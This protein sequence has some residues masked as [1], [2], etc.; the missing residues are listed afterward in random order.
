ML[1]CFEFKSA[2]NRLEHDIALEFYL[3]CMKNSIRYD[4][5]SG[6]FGSTVYIIA[7][8]ALK[9]FIENGGKIRILCSPFISED[10]ADAISKGIASRTNKILKDSLISEL[11][12]MLKQD[13]LSTPS[14]LLA[15]LISA[16]IIELKLV[17]VKSDTNP[18]IVKLFHDKAGIFA[19][20]EN[21]KVGFRGS[22]NETFKGLSDDQRIFFIPSLPKQGGF[23]RVL[24]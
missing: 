13:E 9:T 6:Y 21:Y 18:E 15:C 17:I 4:R 7:W 20:A 2:Y 24:L 22:F 5:I 8:S 11:S 12:D 3:P 10:D 14:R 19:D 1:S 16:G 23:R